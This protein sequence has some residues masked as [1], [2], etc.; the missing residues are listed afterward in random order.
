MILQKDLS[1]G[2]KATGHSSI[3]NVPG[4]DDWYIAY[5]RFGM[6]GGDG[7]HRE[8]TIDKL[9]FGAGG[10][11]KPVVPTLESVLPQTIQLPPTG[12]EIEVT[13]ATRCVAGKVALTVLVKNVDDV[14]ASLS[15]QSAAG[16]KDVVLAAGKSTSAAFT[17]RSASLGSG[18]VGVTATA[19]IDGAPVTSVTPAQYAAAV[20]G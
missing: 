17:T 14:S 1:L 11:I 13:T 2:S 20:C 4:T 10:L 8:T 6:P 3:I 15:I 19:T 16:A 18:T 5:H 9:E 7:T 12:P